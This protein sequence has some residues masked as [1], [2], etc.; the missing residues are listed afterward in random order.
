LQGCSGTQ[1]RDIGMEAGGVI[2][3]RGNTNNANWACLVPPFS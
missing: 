2:A 1:E 3:R